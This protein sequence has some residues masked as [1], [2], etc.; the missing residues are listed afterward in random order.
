MLCSVAQ[1]PMVFRSNDEFIKLLPSVDFSK[2][3]FSM[4]KGV[5]VFFFK[6]MFE[7][8]TLVVIFILFGCWVL[9]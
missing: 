8:N 7:G 6:Y 3:A 5:V 4:L 1:V 9:I 2:N